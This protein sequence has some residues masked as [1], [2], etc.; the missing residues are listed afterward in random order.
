LDELGRRYTLGGAWSDPTYL[1]TGPDAL[2]PMDRGAILGVRC[3]LYPTE[4]PAAAFGAIRY[5]VRDLSKERPVDDRTFEIYRR[6][7][8]YDPIALD[9]KVESVDEGSGH[10]R[11]EK[12]SFAAAYGGERVPARLYLP[13]NARPPFQ[14]VI[15]FPPGSALF[16]PSIE[17]V[18]SRDFAYLVRSGRAV[19]FPVYQQTYER[20]REGRRGPNYARE[21]VTQ[22]ALDVRRAIDFL[23]SRPDIDRE[24]IAFC[25]LSMGAGEGTIVGAVGTGCAPSSSWR[26]R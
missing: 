24:R 12:V 6:L 14:A 22:R 4:P 10:W 26:P 23:E 3:A 15:Y 16:L 20:R 5:V 11:L 1:Y 13:K 8:D 9:V 7:F 25:G 21:V 17:R 19:L 18:G 2:D